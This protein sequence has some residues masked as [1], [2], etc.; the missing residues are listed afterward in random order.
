MFPHGLVFP[1][2][3]QRFMI[4]RL[5]SPQGT[6]G[7]FSKLG[8]LSYSAPPPL[9][10]PQHSTINYQFKEKIKMVSLQCKGMLGHKLVQGRKI[11]KLGL[12][13]PEFVSQ[14]LLIVWASEIFRYLWADLSTFT[15]MIPWLLWHYLLWN[16][17]AQLAHRP[18]FTLSWFTV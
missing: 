15:K 2:V 18:G 11:I 5:P 13:G 6:K 9:Y 8:H 16:Y 12:Q 3:P 7:C 10:P 14:V 4:K 17:F 1:L